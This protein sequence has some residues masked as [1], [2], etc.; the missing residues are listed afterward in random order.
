[1]PRLSLSGRPTAVLM[2]M[3][4][5]VA[6]PEPAYPQSDARIV[7]TVTDSQGQPVEGAT[8]TVDFAGGLTRQFQTTTNAAGEFIQIG[9]AFG[10]YTVTAEKEGVGAMRYDVTLRAGQRLDMDVEL[11]TQEEL[12]RE[13]MSEEDRERMDRNIAATGAFGEGVAATR[14]GDLDEA[15]AKFNL[16]LE[17][18]PKCSDCYRNLGIVHAQREDYAEAEDAFNQALEIEPADAESYDGLAEI[19]NAQRKF[20]EAAEASAE[21]ATLRGGSSTG[22]GNATAVFDQGL[23]FWNAGRLAEARQQFDET[24]RLDPEHGEV[25]YW[26]GMANLNEGKLAEAAAELRIYL[27]REPGGRFAAEA[28]GILGQLP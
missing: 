5:T 15:I 24:L 19:Y 7:G 28:T 25:H 9:L 22:G 10:P 27:E 6:L 18:S 11:L 2:A 13:S 21:A 20:D 3:L 23:I 14:V 26:L 8:V 1:M 16:A 12:I 4:V 17:S